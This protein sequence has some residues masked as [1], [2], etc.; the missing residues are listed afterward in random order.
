MLNVIDELTRKC[1][2]IHVD[3][4]IDAD[5]VVTVLDTLTAH[6]AVASGAL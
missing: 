4:S 6:A 2:A 3:H 5:Q 1:L